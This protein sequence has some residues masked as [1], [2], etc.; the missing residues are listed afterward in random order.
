MGKDHLPVQRVGRVQTIPPSYAPRGGA[1]AEDGPDRP[2]SIAVAA[3]PGGGSRTPPLDRTVD[4]RKVHI[5]II[6]CSHAH[7]FVLMVLAHGFVFEA[8]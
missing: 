6:S 2:P 7:E 4:F 5:P 3:E 8:V 1:E